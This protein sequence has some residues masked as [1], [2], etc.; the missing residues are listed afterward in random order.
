MGF[1]LV[2]VPAHA[3]HAAAGVVNADD[4]KR[5]VSYFWNEQSSEVVEKDEAMKCLRA[6]LQ[7]QLDNEATD[8]KKAKVQDSEDENRR[9]K[10]DDKVCVRCCVRVQLALI[11]VRCRTCGTCAPTL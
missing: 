7:D 9:K 1:M 5:F 6:F 4:L 2:P 10:R 3:M 11:H 8:T